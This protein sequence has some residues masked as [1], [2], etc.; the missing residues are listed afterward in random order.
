MELNSV[1]FPPGF[2]VKMTLILSSVL[3]YALFKA[4]HLDRTKR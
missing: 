1:E 2:V 3:Y 4:I